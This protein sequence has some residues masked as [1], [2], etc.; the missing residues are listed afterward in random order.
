MLFSFK[1]CLA[2]QRFSKKALEHHRPLLQT[3]PAIPAL[4]L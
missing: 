3:C 2:K 1:T 4:L